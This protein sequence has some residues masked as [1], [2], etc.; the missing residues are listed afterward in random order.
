MHKPRPDRHYVSYATCG[1][2]GSVLPATTD[3]FAGAELTVAA[4]P[5]DQYPMFFPT[6]GAPAS[7][8][9]GVDYNATTYE[10][11]MLDF[12]TSV[13]WSG[14]LPGTRSGPRYL[15]ESLGGAIGAVQPVS[16]SSLEDAGAYSAVFEDVAR[17]VAD[18]AVTWVY[19]NPDRLR[20]APASVAIV[21]TTLELWAPRPRVEDPSFAKRVTTVFAPF[22]ASLWAALL[23]LIVVV[24]VLRAALDAPHAPS[25]ARGAAA[26]GL[27][28]AYTSAMDLFAGGVNDSEKTS[29][30]SRVLLFGW[31][32]RA[33]A[34]VRFE[35]PSY[36]ASTPTP[37]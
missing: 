14:D 30:A 26:A 37:P 3:A 12:L 5:Y 17:G 13:S 11:A 27:D 15:V 8:E 18:A 2:D 29:P 31:G 19:D 32:F 34:G 4:P 35:P 28:A 1:G 33:S 20:R 6:D 10:G 21:T 23:G 25:S 36:L 24:G 22:D 7:D 9:V 16:R